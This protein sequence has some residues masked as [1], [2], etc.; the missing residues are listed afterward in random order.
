MIQENLLEKINDVLTEQLRTEIVEIVTYVIRS[1]IA[2]LVDGEFIRIHPLVMDAYFIDELNVDDTIID[3][4]CK[5]VSIKDIIYSE[6]SYAVD[7]K[8]E[9]RAKALVSM[10]EEILENLKNPP[11]SFD[12]LAEH[13]SNRC[14]SYEAAQQATSPE[15]NSNELE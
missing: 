4:I 1:Q 9:A 15:N 7:E 14:D 5:H 13:A 12:W 3:K 6:M 8:D 11:E 2:H 10:I